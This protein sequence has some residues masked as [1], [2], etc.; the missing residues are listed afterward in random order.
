[1]QT[2]FCKRQI[3]QEYITNIFKLVTNDIRS[4]EAF[5]G[6][7]NVARLFCIIKHRNREYHLIRMSAYKVK[8]LKKRA[9]LHKI[10]EYYGKI[11]IKIL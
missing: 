5:A 8:T 4:R 10:N 2:Y 3:I 6:N 1:M 7:C 11:L 9:N